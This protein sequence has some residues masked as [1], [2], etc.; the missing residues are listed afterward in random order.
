MAW[1]GFVTAKEHRHQ[2]VNLIQQ[3]F[4]DTINQS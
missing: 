1:L 4:Y 2:V 3:N